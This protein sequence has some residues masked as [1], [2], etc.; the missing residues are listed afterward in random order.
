MTHL[1]Q[2][3]VLRPVPAVGRVLVFDT[4]THI[5]P[6]PALARLRDEFDP[7]RGVLGVGL[8][9][10][11]RMDATVP[12]LRAFPAVSGPGI[13]FPSTQGGLVALLGGEQPGE[14]YDRATALASTLGEGFRLREDTA[15]FRYREGRD[16]SGYLDGTANPEGEAAIEAAIV[17]DE[18][19]GLDGSTFV[20]VQRYVHDLARLAALDPGA[21][22]QVIGRRNRDNAEMDDAPPTA[23]V[24]R[25]EQ[26]GFD[27]PAFMVRRSMPWGGVAEQGLMFVA[28]GDSPDRYERVLRRMAG[29][30]DGVVDA[31]LGF[32]RAVSGG[33][34]WCPPVRD[35]K[36]DWSALGLR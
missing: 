36:L 28:Y 24:K 10:V 20:G 25:T 21:R 6:R 3:A 27:P 1:W 13:A 29:L 15:T 30:D 17:L 9:L 11:A 32:T 33:Y 23:H 26:E 14:V 35:G 34:Y 18:G 7:A 12:G 8:P 4:D 22:D 2:A 19:P 16:L 5:D 31:L